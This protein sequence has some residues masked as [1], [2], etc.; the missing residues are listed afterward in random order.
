MLRN[1]KSLIAGL[2]MLG[3]GAYLLF[4]DPAS[5]PLWFIWTVGPLLWY[6]GFALSLVG[7]MLRLFAHT[8]KRIAEAE[9][10]H[11]E[12]FVLPLQK[13]SR[14]PAGVLHEIPSMGGFIW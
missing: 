9:V 3:S 2:L 12:V 1:H 4:G 10:Q 5:L 11:Q 14:P 6:L 7:V 8:P 13:Y